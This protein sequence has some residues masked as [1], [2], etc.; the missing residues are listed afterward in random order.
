PMAI[1]AAG[2]GFYGAYYVVAVAVGRVKRTQFNWVVT[3][4]AAA[5]SIGLCFPFSERW[6]ATGAAASTA[7][8]YVVMALMMALRGEQVFRVGC[9]WVRLGLLLGVAAAMFVVADASLPELGLLGIASRVLVALAYPLGLLVTG[10]FRPEER[11]RLRSL[12]AAF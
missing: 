3:G 6:Q 4:A 8:A 11:R 5:I 1:T 10:F 7:I 2:I 9:E 12:R